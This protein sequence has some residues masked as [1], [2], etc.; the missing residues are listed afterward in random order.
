MTT[1]HSEL[2]ETLYGAHMP[3]NHECD[4]E[5]IQS[6]SEQQ[7]VEVRFEL[8]RRVAAMLVLVDCINKEIERR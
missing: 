4:I 7:L 5:V 1:P 6:L 8:G 2:M 3:E